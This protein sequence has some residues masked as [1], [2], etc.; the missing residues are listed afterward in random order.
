MA[1]PAC[2]VNELALWHARGL[3]MS[4]KDKDALVL[5]ALRSWTSDVP[6]PPRDIHPLGTL[7]RQHW[8]GLRA[9]PSRPCMRPLDRA[10]FCAIR[11]PS[12]VHAERPRPSPRRRIFGLF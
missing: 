5:N 12:E 7:L 8:F 9:G 4:G 10:G 2:R 1:G 6:A 3:G 11:E